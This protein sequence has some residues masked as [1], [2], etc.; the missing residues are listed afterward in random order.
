M[1]MHDQAD[2]RILQPLH[3]YTHT[4][5]NPVLSSDPVGSQ[6]GDVPLL[7]PARRGRR[8]KQRAWYHPRENLEVVV[9]GKTALILAHLCPFPGLGASVSSPIKWNSNSCITRWL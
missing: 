1:G 3:T 7:F 4:T 2:V 8:D 9:E 5:G 6:V